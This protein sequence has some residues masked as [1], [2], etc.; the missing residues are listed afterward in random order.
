MFPLMLAGSLTPGKA[1][2]QVKILSWNAAGESFSRGGGASY[3]DSDGDS[4]IEVIFEAVEGGTKITLTH[5]N[6]P[7]DQGSHG[8]GWSTHYFEPMK[9]FFGKEV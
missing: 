3:K 1:T 7:D 8:T 5:T 2:S 6:V 9:S 4:K